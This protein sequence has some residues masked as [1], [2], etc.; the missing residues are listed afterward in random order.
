MEDVST[1]VLE[2]IKNIQEGKTVYSQFFL[3]GY[4]VIKLLDICEFMSLIDS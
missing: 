1:K 2:K 4:D 3:L